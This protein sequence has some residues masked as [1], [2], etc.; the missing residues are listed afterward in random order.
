MHVPYFA[1]GTKL[2]AL[3]TL[4]FAPLLFTIQWVWGTWVSHDVLQWGLVCLPSP[5]LKTNV[6]F[7][8]NFQQSLEWWSYIWTITHI[9]IQMWTC[10]SNFCMIF[11]NVYVISSVIK[12][13]NI[14]NFISWDENDL[15]ICWLR[16]TGMLSTVESSTLALRWA[17]NY[18]LSSQVNHV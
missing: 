7:S 15:A 9:F 4:A 13:H 17:K 14:C 6:F 2:N 18:S 12:W 5:S 8:L 1:S 10:S 16:W 11:G 3:L